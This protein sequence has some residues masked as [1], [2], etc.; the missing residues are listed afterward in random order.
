MFSIGDWIV[1]ANYGVGQIEGKDTKVIAGKEEMYYQ[2]KTR[3]SMFWLSANNVDN[4]RVRPLATPME[5]SQVINILKEPPR[6]MSSNYKARQ[7]WIVKLNAEGTMEATAQL[8]RDLY[9]RKFHKQLNETEE[10]MLRRFER[11]FVT[12]WGLALNVE[13]NE[14]R[15]RLARILESNREKWV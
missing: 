13:I 11:R 9:A 8:V 7:G 1:H 12:E 2:V 5:V 6:E 10:M 15:R 4:R 3:D 14:V